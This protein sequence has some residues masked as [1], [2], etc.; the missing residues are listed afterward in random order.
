MAAREMTS[1][2]ATVVGISFV[3]MLLGGACARSPLRPEDRTSG[4]SASAERRIGDLSGGGGGEG[5]CHED[6]PCPPDVPVQFELLASDGSGFTGECLVSASGQLSSFFE[7][8][9]DGFGRFAGGQLVSGFTSEDLTG[10]FQETSFSFPSST[11]TAVILVFSA[12]RLGDQ[13]FKIEA[14]LDLTVVNIADWLSCAAS[15]TIL[16]A[17]VAG[18]LPQLGRVTGTFVAPCIES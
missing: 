11:T 12:P 16:D 10:P 8:S 6:E 4:A 9:G 1:T 7:C 3:A 5:V 17:S 15:G 2:V 18:A 13:T 14:T